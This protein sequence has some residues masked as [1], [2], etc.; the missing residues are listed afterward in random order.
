MA[1]KGDYLYLW[2]TTRKDHWIDHSKRHR[3][4]N[5]ERAKRTEREGRR[6]NERPPVP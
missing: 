5:G 3:R 2:D 4:R 1:K 6:R